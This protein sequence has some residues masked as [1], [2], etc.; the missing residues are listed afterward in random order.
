MTGNRSVITPPPAMVERSLMLD[1]SPGI[2]GLPHSGVPYFF[3]EQEY[4][5]SAAERLLGPHGVSCPNFRDYV[6]NLLRFVEA[7]P[8]L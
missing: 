8:K 5:T 1:M 7:H 4:D 3:I 6:A 2:T